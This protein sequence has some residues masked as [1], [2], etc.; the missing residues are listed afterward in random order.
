[1]T[2]WTRD[3]LARIGSSN[4]VEV[5]ARRPDG[6]LRGSVTIWVVPHGDTT[7]ELIPR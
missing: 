7:L 3:E 4:E 1:M 2:R 6:T 5:A